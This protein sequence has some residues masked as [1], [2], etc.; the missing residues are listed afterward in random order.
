MSGNGVDRATLGVAMTSDVKGIA[1]K[2]WWWWL[3]SIK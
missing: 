3:M 2:G 1:N